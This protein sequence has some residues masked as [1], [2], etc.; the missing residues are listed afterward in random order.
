MKKL[1]TILFLLVSINVMAPLAPWGPEEPGGPPSPP[2]GPPCWPPP[3]VP[4]DGGIFT[5]TLIAMLF[6]AKKIKDNS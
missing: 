2:P 3:C 4:V 6:G 1:L 5:F